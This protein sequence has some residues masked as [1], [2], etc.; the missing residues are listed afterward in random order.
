MLNLFTTDDSSI[1]NLL[2]K[3]LPNIVR[4]VVLELFNRCIGERSLPASWKASS[5]TM[6]PK[7]SIDLHLVKSYRPIS[8]TPSLGKLLESIIQGRLWLHVNTNNILIP[9]QSGFRPMRQTKDNIFYLVQKSLQNFNRNM[10]SR[11]R[12]EEK[13]KTALITFDIKG[14]FNKV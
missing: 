4:E 9:Q 11:R 7:K 5:I 10:H 2:I 13:I 12:P 3:K 1:N 6:I 14:A 8:I